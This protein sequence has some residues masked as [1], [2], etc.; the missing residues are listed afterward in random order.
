[1][2][3]TL[4]INILDKYFTINLT[5]IFLIYVSIYFIFFLTYKNIY[6]LLNKKLHILLKINYNILYIKRAHPDLNRNFWL[7]RPTLYPLSYR[8]I[9]FITHFFNTTKLLKILKQHF[10]SNLL[11]LTNTP[12]SQDKPTAAMFF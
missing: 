8:R 1:M 4:A 7:R 2:N 11:Y 12:Y 5:K 6:P 10:C 3:I 9:H